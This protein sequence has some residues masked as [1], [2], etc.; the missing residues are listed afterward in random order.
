MKDL[1]SGRQVLEL[2]QLENCF[3]KLENKKKLTIVGISQ[4]FKRRRREASLT[5]RFLNAKILRRALLPLI[6]LLQNTSKFPLSVV[7]IINPF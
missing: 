4:G 5:R 2:K 1:R 6:T 3:R 7:P